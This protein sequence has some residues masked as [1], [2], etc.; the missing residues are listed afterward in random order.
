MK[1]TAHELGES[2]ARELVRGYDVRISLVEGS[3]YELTCLDRLTG[4]P[5][6]ATTPAMPGT[7]PDVPWYLVAA[8]LG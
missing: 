7:M 5:V 2:V 6:T 8:G 3:R 4:E 1:L